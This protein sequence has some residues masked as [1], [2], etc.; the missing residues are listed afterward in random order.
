[1]LKPLVI[2]CEWLGAN[3]PV[4]LARI[5][6][7]VRFRRLLNLKK[8]ENLNEKMLF[9]SL[10]TDTTEWTMLAD[11][12]AVRD[13]VWSLGLEDILV[14]LYGA[15]DKAEDCDFDR[16]PDR[17]VLKCNHGSGDILIVKDKS[18]INRQEVIKTFKKHL[19]TPYGAVESGKHYLR[20]K[21]KLIA[22]GL[23]ENDPVSAQFSSS[24]IDYKIWCF[25]GKPAY[26]WVCCNRDKHG[27]DVMTYD[28]DWIAHP[29]YSIWTQN[30]RR[31][32]LIP[33]PDNYDLMMS[34]AE[35]LAGSFPVVSVDLYNLGGKVY[36]GEMTFTRLGAMINFYT[37]EFLRM[38][39]ERISIK[40]LEK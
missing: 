13:Y 7:F 28:L 5:R 38:C 36:F 39:G 40:E 6:Y 16:L 33:K 3:H 24:L 19:A 15:W 35:K 21:P 18:Q 27:C 1:M 8:P 34:I 11:K 29:E 14:Q 25:N 2:L 9:L 30:Y 12:Y 20:I 23:L 10:K 37:P 26:T 4:F 22:E 17:F 31:G 32:E